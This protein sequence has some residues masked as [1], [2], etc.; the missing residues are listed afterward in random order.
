MK[1]RTGRAQLLQRIH[2]QKA[3][4]TKSRANRAKENNKTF[5]RNTKNPFNINSQE[6]KNPRSV[7]KMKE[8]NEREFHISVLHLEKIPEN[9]DS[10][11]IVTQ[12]DT[13][14]MMTKLA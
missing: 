6:E 5:K 14:P 8:I 12:W 13:K 9:K 7:R 3:E 11:L 2:I 4:N 1:I 10:N